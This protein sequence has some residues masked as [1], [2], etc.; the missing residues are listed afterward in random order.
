M[1]ARDPVVVGVDCRGGVHIALEGVAE[2]IHRN[3]AV[4]HVVVGVELVAVGKHH[5]TLYFHHKHYSSLKATRN[6]VE[7]RDIGYAGEGAVEFN[8]IQPSAHVSRPDSA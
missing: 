6:P 3:D 8:L 1:V 2:V 5:A 4:V 7:R